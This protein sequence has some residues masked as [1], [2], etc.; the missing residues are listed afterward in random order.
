MFKNL[1]STY[2]VMKLSGETLG[3]NEAFY[4]ATYGA[5]KG[6]NLDKRIGKI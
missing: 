2:K 4:Y 3:T 6:L 5:A 1:G